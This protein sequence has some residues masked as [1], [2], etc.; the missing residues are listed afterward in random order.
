M[1]AAPQ[2][3]AVAMPA[4]ITK[5]S[6]KTDVQV[7]APQLEAIAFR[8]FTS[9]RVLTAA[10]NA[11]L[12]EPKIFT[13]KPI[14]LYAAL[15]RVAR[16]GLDIGDTVYL[17][18]LSVKVSKRGEPDRWETVVE[19]WPDYKG[20]KAL[21]IR[22]GLVRSM[23][24]FVVYE[25]DKF[26]YQLGLDA[27]LKHWPNSD[28]SKRG[29]IRGAYTVIRLPHSERTFN[30]MPIADIE[31]V[32][33]GSKTWGPDK[34]TVCPEW[35]AMKTTVRDYLNRQPKQGALREALA[36][37]DTEQTPYDP[38]TGEVLEAPS[39]TTNA[40]EPTDAELD[41]MLAGREG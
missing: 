9:D 8:G 3:T 23:E 24:E 28:P 37:D 40:S 41:Q 26:E 22:E 32:R 13:A 4:E 1:T 36:A 2:S 21:A 34:V 29:G 16:W 12:R 30:Y 18:P 38:D 25:G 31:K 19:A 14:S 6:F 11:A 5:V 10:L 17:V 7:W 15:C 39:Q 33:K 20:L 27:N 35:Y